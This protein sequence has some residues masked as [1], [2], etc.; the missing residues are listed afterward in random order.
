LRARSEA[1]RS[2]PLRSQPPVSKSVRT[3]YRR[4]RWTVV[5]LLANTPPKRR[6]QTP[7]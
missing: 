6:T 7:G 5:Q 3:G 1:H 4:R 2:V